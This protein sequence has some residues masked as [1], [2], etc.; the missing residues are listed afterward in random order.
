MLQGLGNLAGMLKQAKELQGKMK[1]MQEEM[2]TRRFEAQSGGGMV[3]VAVNG[4]GELVTVKIDPQAVSD[5]E[6]LEDLVKAAVNAGQTRARE[7]LQ[8]EMAKMTGGMNLP[9][10]SNLMGGGGS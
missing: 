3:Q 9:G 4:K 1:E 8:E 10:L 2:A 7:A 6:M 5:V